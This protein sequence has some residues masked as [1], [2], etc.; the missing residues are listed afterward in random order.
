MTK[1]EIQ[2]MHTMKKEKLMAGTFA[3]IR[4]SDFEQLR[5]EHITE[6]AHMYWLLRGCPEG[7]PEVDWVKAEME[8]DREILAEMDLGQPS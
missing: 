1:R 4:Y 8:V 5:D 2:G 7:S 6:L 3:G